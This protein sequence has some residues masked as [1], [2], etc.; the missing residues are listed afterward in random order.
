[1]LKMILP[2]IKKRN[3][4]LLLLTTFSLVFCAEKKPYKN[5]SSRKLADTSTKQCKICSKTSDEYSQY[6]K[7][8]DTTKINMDED[9]TEE[10]NSY[11]VKALINIVGNY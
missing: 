8:G 5:L 6:Y 9:N 2:H 3:I 11:Y 7:S 1:M 10:Y 4:F